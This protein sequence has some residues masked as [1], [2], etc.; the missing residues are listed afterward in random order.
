LTRRIAKGETDARANIN[1]RDEFSLVANSMNRMLDNIVQLI[2]Q[3]QEQR[4]ELQ[5]QVEN[6][7]N[8]VSGIAEGDLRIQA[9]VSSSTLG[10]LAD[11]FNYMIE[12]LASL[13]VRVKTVA[14]EVARSTTGI[15]TRMNQLAETGHIQLQQIAHAEK[16]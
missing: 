1:G 7:V 12:E 15:L 14:N 10:V 3:A 11:S 4:D 13:V 5:A 2:Q 9:E 8:E 6:L 16:E